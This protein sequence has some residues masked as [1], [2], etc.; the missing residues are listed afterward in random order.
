MA[1]SLVSRRRFTFWLMAAGGSLVVSRRARAA[2]FEMRQFHNQPAESP[3]HKSLV[4]MWA[5]V[6][7]ET[8]GRV[9]VQ[10]F[11]DNDHLSGRDTAALSML[12]DGSLDFMTLNGGLIGAVVPAVNIQGIP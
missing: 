11:L 4:E 2:E 9:V 5:A 7:Q 10:T 12:I 8:G 3:L 6:K 1:G